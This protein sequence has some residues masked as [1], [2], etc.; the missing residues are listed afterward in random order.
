MEEI[1][2]SLKQVRGHTYDT[3]Y[4]L[5]FTSERVI[6]YLIQ[7]PSDMPY[8]TGV[9]ETLLIGN[10]RS[11]HSER[12][13]R[14]KIA[15]ERENILREQS[16]DDL[17]AAHRLNQEIRYDNIETVELKRGMFDSSLRFRTSEKAGSYFNLKFTMDKKQLTE[18][19]E[20]L[21][22]VLPGKIKG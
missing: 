12:M 5:I 20:L 11:K 4:E 7:S 22:Q 16:L 9:F 13:E 14:K 3:L 19:R 6:T 21:D 17:V 10:W 2:G 15:D 18:A 8:S 1:I